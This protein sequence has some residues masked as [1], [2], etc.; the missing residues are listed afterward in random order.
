MCVHENA[1]SHQDIVNQRPEVQRRTMV[2][3][4]EMSDR[5]SMH[6]ETLGKLRLGQLPLDTPCGKLGS[7]CAPEIGDDALT[8]RHGSSVTPATHH[9][10]VGRRPIAT[11]AA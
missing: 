4:F 10:T 6:V 2:A 7:E 1:R 9:R 11:G 8:V 3:G 5:R